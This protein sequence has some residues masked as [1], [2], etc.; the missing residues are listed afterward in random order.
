VTLT[1]RHPAPVI[2][3]PA[4]AIRAFGAWEL[5]TIPDRPPGYT[6]RRMSLLSRV[7][8]ECGPAG[9]LTAPPSA[10]SRRIYRDRHDSGRKTRTARGLEAAIEDFRAWHARTTNTL[11]SL[12]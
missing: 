1:A 8:E 9:L 4:A 12:S 2:T 3:P 7:L 10:V 5:T 11:P 6:A